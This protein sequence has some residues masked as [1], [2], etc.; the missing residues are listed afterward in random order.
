MLFCS[1]V[2][3]FLS[4]L[5]ILFLSF[6]FGIISCL[7]LCGGWVKTGL[8]CVFLLFCCFVGTGWDDVL[9]Y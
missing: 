4:F 3:G 6:F 2:G 1:I 5:V 8:V 9:V 7:F